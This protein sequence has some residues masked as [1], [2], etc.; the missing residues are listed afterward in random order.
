ME[1]VNASKDFLVNYKKHFNTFKLKE[2]I[3]LVFDMGG[4]IKNEQKRV[5]QVLERSR[6]IFTELLCQK[7]LWL[8]LTIWDYNTK[9][10]LEELTRC[11]FDFN[12]AT[13]FFEI[14]DSNDLEYNEQ[15]DAKTYCL[16][17]EKF[18]FEDIYPLL[19]A[20]ASYELALNYSA[21]VTAYFISFCSSPVLI[22][23]YDDRGL[24]VL[25]KD[26]YLFKRMYYKF[27]KYILDY[28]RER[29]KKYISLISD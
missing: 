8:R 9:N 26:K 1:N 25:I 24:E 13:R 5:N 23:L 14:S 3:Q 12:K 2:A 16:Y 18:N 10:T 17:Y 28:H 27:E 4:K 20:I 7:D 29:I 11:G 6:E 21:N 22:N 19:S 15:F